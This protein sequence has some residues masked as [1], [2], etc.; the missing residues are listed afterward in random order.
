MIL[1]CS[2]GDQ[3]EM[4][5]KKSGSLGWTFPNDCSR[6]LNRLS[7]LY[8]R[9]IFPLLS[10]FSL[11][12]KFPCKG[13]YVV[14]NLLQFSWGECMTPGSVKRN[15]TIQWKTRMRQSYIVLRYMELIM[16]FSCTGNLIWHY[17]F[18]FHCPVVKSS[19]FFRGGLLAM[20]IICDQRDAFV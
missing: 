13:R 6:S 18:K 11:V 9:I 17:I 12:V 15:F 10:L 4:N 14:G 19:L 5:G 2:F 7:S 20:W 16:S 8:E 1:Y 3:R